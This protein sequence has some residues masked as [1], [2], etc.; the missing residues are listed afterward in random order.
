MVRALG[1]LCGLLLAL[2][3]PL[4]FAQSSGA[5]ASSSTVAPLPTPSGV[6]FYLVCDQ[7]QLVIS[8]TSGASSC[9]AVQFVQSPS[10]L[11]YMPVSAAASI[12]VAILTVWA[13]AALYRRL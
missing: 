9:K 3:S 1:V 7:T 10:L 11:P 6:V 5:P 4:A 13:L 12:S 2:V 8:P